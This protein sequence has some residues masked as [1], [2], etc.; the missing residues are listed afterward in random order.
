M[1]T[2]LYR[3][4]IS[5]PKLVPGTRQKK[6]KSQPSHHELSFT[7][8][9][10]WMQSWLSLELRVRCNLRLP[11][12]NFSFI[13]MARCYGHRVTVWR[14]NGPHGN[15]RPHEKGIS[16]GPD[17]AHVHCLPPAELVLPVGELVTDPHKPPASE[18]LGRAVI[19]PMDCWPDVCSRLSL[20]PAEVVTRSIRAMNDP[21]SQYDLL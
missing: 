15:I 4:L 11:E 6:P 12:L 20:Q 8:E 17:D 9:A 10:D 21:N 3:D 5:R 19:G 2:L 1:T 13:L 14:L 16:T 7:I 18:I